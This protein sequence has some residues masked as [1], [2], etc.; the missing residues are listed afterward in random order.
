MGSSCA[1]VA[2]VHA[3]VSGGQYN[4]IK[5][6]EKEHIILLLNNQRAIAEHVTLAS[7]SIHSI[8]LKGDEYPHIENEANHAFKI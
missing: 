5:S 6:S 8:N 4:C 7:V 2:K 1:V 3:Q